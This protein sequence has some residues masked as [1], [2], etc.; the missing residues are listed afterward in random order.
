MPRARWIACVV[1]AAACAPPPPPRHAPPPPPPRPTTTIAPTRPAP[2]APKA[3]PVT[4]TII[5]TNDLHGA[6]DRLPIFAGFVANVRAARA[7]DGGAVI[8]V[9]GGDM[10]QGT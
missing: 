9:D 5:G 3:A 1:L 6:L 10:F 7:A 2:P 4:L 8:V